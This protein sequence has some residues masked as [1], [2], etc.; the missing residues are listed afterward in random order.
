MG[1]SKKFLLGS[2]LT[3]SCLTTGCVSN[4]VDDPT[5][6]EYEFDYLITDSK[7]METSE[8]PTNVGKKH[9]YIRTWDTVRPEIKDGKR[10]MQ[11]AAEFTYDNFMA[12]LNPDTHLLSVD[13]MAGVGESGCHELLKNEMDAFFANNE[14]NDINYVVFGAHGDAAGGL[15]IFDDGVI[16]TDNYSHVVKLNKVFEWLS[17]YKG[18]FYVFVNACFCGRWL[19]PNYPNMSTNFINF[20][21]SYGD[22]FVV[23]LEASTSNL[24]TPYYYGV[25]DVDGK[26]SAGIVPDA[27]N[28]MDADIDHDGNVTLDEIFYY[29]RAG[30]GSKGTDCHYYAPNRGNEI[31]ISNHTL[32]LFSTTSGSLASSG[33]HLIFNIPDNKIIDSLGMPTAKEGYKFAYWSYDKQGKNRVSF[34]FTLSE[35][36]KLFANYKSE[37]E[38]IELP[39]GYISA[40]EK[41]ILRIPYK[42]GTYGDFIILDFK[43]NDDKEGMFLVSKDIAGMT[44]FPNEGQTEG[45]YF[46]GTKAQAWCNEYMNKLFPEN[47]INLISPSN[48]SFG[49]GDS[50]KLDNEKVFFLNKDE[51][52]KYFTTSNRGLKE[53]YFLMSDGNLK[54][55]YVGTS[56]SIY[57][58]GSK[59][60]TEVRGTRPAFNLSISKEDLAFDPD[61]ETFYIKSVGRYIK[62]A[63]QRYDGTYTVKTDGNVTYTAS[64][65][66]KLVCDN[67]NTLAS[68][69][70][71]TNV[72]FTYAYNETDRFLFKAGGYR[73]LVYNELDRE[74]Y[75]Y[76][77]IDTCID[78]VDIHGTD[79]GAAISASYSMTFDYKFTA[80][81]M[82]QPDSL[83]TIKN[84]AAD[85]VTSGTGDIRDYKDVGRVKYQDYV[86]VVGSPTL[87]VAS[88]NDTGVFLDGIQANL[89][90]NGKNIN[91]DVYA[92]ILPGDMI[93][94]R[95]TID[96]GADISHTRLI[97]AV[98]L[99][100][101]GSGKIDPDLSKV[102]FAD[103]SA[104]QVG[105][106]IY[107]GQL[108]SFLTSDVYSESGANV[109]SFSDLLVSGYLPVTLNNWE[110]G[111]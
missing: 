103:T 31:F 83:Y 60:N 35:N 20:L 67:M 97:T 101:N 1:R 10:G 85:A 104:P 71:E 81:D 110:T 33:E 27:N 29:G 88:N 11:G 37:D 68:T 92:N 74:F 94:A 19:D 73:G 77:N 41:D 78:G 58:N 5:S 48:A 12:A 70:W 50:F 95:G 45:Y 43:T 91:D 63:P 82:T 24:Y 6:K 111:H 51:A 75:D 15:A 59:A 65:N 100:H 106:F 72:G 18:K 99:V 4:P 62:K 109:M 44:C 105:R 76:E 2:L 46:D 56:G 7:A 53:S 47:A 86:S 57:Y 17:Q 107:G 36:T 66:R 40:K 28:K 16:S 9:L 26:I 38:E 34:P 79:A 93:I 3:L 13:P 42:D 98:E 39:S 32:E 23:Y 89:D 84:F 25:A 55:C 69:Y 96:T 52:N 30:F 8:I 102:I 61:S 22:K 80:L 108:T 87:P 90:N 64:G 54:N 14:D 21:D 49:S